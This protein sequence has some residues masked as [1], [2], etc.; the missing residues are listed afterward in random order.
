MDDILYLLHA[1][2]RKVMAIHHHD[3]PKGTGTEAVYGFQCDLFIRSCFPWLDSQLPLKFRGDRFT[4]ANMAGCSQADR[5][6][7]VSLSGFKLKAL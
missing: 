1:H 5:D 6:E 7:D 3:R 4:S 2:V